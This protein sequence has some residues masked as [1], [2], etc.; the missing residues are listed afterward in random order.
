MV[1]ML[2]GRV[3]PG[4]REDLVRFLREAVP[5]Y[6]RPAGILTRLLWDVDDPDAFV[7]LIE[8]ADRGTYERDQERVAVDP[9]IRGLLGR[10]HTLLAGALTVET[11][12]DLTTEI[13]AHAAPLRDGRGF[14]SPLE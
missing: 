14:P 7:E 9:E 10:W 3:Q 1:I 12:E 5:C 2:R 13:H 4:R 8:Y 6:E 11:Y